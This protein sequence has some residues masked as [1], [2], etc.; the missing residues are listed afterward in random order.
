MFQWI[1]CNGKWWKFWQYPE[2]EIQKKKEVVHTVTF[3]EIHV[4]NSRQKGFLALFNGDVGEIKREVRERIDTK[5]AEWRE[6][7]RAEI[8][9][10]VLFIDE[11]HI[12]DLECFAFSKE[13]LKVKQPQWLLWLLIEVLL[14]LEEN[15]SLSS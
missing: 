1:W 6:N 9:P 15:S 8:V 2:G 12:L 5:L 7:E 13:Q 10:G 3:H 4:I 14:K 11:V